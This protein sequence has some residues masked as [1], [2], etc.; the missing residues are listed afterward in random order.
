MKEAGRGE[1][2]KCQ[3][4]TPV[5]CQ[6]PIQGTDEVLIGFMPRSLSKARRFIGAYINF[7]YACSVL[8]NP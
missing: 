2:R 3:E 6:P 8:L 4:Q 1:D 5:T 7:S